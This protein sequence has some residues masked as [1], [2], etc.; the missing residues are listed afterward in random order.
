MLH[1]DTINNNM[2]FV[3]A[4]GLPSHRSLP[5]GRD[6][7]RTRRRLT[8]L[9][10]PALLRVLL[11][12]AARKAAGKSASNS[13]RSTTTAVSTSSIKLLRAPNS[14]C[15][16]V[17]ALQTEGRPSA[18]DIDQQA[19]VGTRR[20]APEHTKKA[21]QVMKDFQSETTDTMQDQDLQAGGRTHRGQRPRNSLMQSSIASH[22]LGAAWWAEYAIDEEE[23]EVLLP[24]DLWSIHSVLQQGAPDMLSSRISGR[25]QMAQT[26]YSLVYTAL[27][28]GTVP[29]VVKVRVPFDGILKHTMGTDVSCCMDNVITLRS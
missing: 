20:W 13:S 1:T 25:S 23:E 15:D 5:T 12:A 4:Q 2:L 18:D 16:N 26:A 10:D 27:L 3:S 7:V 24:E 21:A 19:P 22:A 6:T 9:L 11:P 29:V 17:V 14:D 8:Q 28:D